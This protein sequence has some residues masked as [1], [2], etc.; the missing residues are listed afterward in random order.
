MHGQGLLLRADG[1]CIY[2]CIH[3]H[4]NTDILTLTYTLHTY[5]G[6]STHAH[7]HA[8]ARAHTHTQASATREASSEISGAGTAC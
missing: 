8:R 6:E 7:T 1:I 3:A 2:T 5:I 4:I